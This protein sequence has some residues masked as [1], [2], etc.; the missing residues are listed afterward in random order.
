MLGGMGRRPGMRI[1]KHPHQNS[2]RMRTPH[3]SVRHVGAPGTDHGFDSGAPMRCGRGK[4]GGVC[5]PR[6]RAA[7]ACLAAL[8]G[9]V[10][11]LMCAGVF[12]RRARVLLF[13]CFRGVSEWLQIV[14]ESDSYIRLCLRGAVPRY[15]RS[16]IGREG[17]RGGAAIVI[18]PEKVGTFRVFS[19]GR[20]AAPGDSL[21]ACASFG[22]R[23]TKT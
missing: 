18:L 8:A 19:L 21:R 20:Q 22:G 12:R 16:A 3:R 23:H 14:D 7:G 9:S 5:C 6:H 11:F 10:R 17:T 1:G 4:G 13:S 15:V 2:E